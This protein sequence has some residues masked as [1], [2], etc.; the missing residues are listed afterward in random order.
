MCICIK[1]PGDSGRPPP[2]PRELVPGSAAACSSHFL[3]QVAPPEFPK[4]T[5]LSPCR[6]GK[7]SLTP[8]QRFA[9][10][11]CGI[12]FLTP[13]VSSSSN[14]NTPTC[15]QPF[16]GMS[17][18]STHTTPAP[19]SVCGSCQTQQCG[20]HNPPSQPRSQRRP[21]DKDLQGAFHNMV[22]YPVN[23]AVTS[24]R[25]VSIQPVLDEKL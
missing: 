7:Q 13:R 19:P 22:S 23:T 2:S 12:S 1:S 25:S 6:Q 15:F 10:Q 18:I 9:L 14:I 24:G 17:P 21:E 5:Q 20:G 4:G 16:P 3:W 11:R 8:Y